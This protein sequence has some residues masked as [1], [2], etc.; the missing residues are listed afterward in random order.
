MITQAWD[1]KALKFEFNYTMK[2]RIRALTFLMT[3]TFALLHAPNAQ[4]H[5][6]QLLVD[7]TIRYGNQEGDL[8]VV[9]SAG[10]APSGPK[11]F[12]VAP[13]GRL[14]VGD[15]VN[16]RVLIHSKNGELLRS[17]PVREFNISDLA[18]DESG[19]IF[20]YDHGRRTIAEFD[21]SGNLLNTLAV[22]PAA[23]EILGYFHIAGSSIYF[24]NAANKDVLIA[25]ASGG[26]LS[27]P[28]FVSDRRSDGIHSETGRIY[29]V[30][31]ER[32]SLLKVRVHGPNDAA[33]LDTSLPVSGILS[34]TYI[35]ESQSG[36]F[37]I[38]TERAEG[39]RVV[40]EVAT[41]DPRGAFLSSTVV[42]END[43]AFWTTKLLA[44]RRSDG[45]IIQ[46]LPK[47]NQ[48]KLRV[49]LQ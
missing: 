32:G 34:A 31:I 5:S 38:Q 13:D 46:F 19:N 37:Y 25:S 23:I 28:D 48:A 10:D 44:V 35:G 17:V 2:T 41:F 20:V 26:V 3:A 6:G 16:N 11:S 47:A 22:D 8:G 33:G 21:A 43:Y 45:A 42:P 1:D 14:F 4:S 9:R 7:K 18:V 29:A 39:N 15:S 40:L 12:T 27:P 36:R 24:A 30:D 49:I